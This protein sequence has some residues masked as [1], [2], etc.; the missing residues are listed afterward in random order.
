MK[1]TD[2]AAAFPAVGASLLPSLSCPACWPAYASMLSAV[3]LSFLA[4]SKY[5]L[6]LNLVALLAGLVVLFRR[7]RTRGYGPFAVA[8]AASTLILLGKFVLISNRMTWSGA[9]ILLAAFVWSGTHVQP[10]PPC[11]RCVT[12]PS[13]EALEN[14]IKES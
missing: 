5:L 12:T 13:V 7:A 10:A 6:W 2:V 3:G 11:P 9:A 4:E 1:R 14:G 8:I